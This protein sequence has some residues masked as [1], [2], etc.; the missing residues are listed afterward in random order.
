[1]RKAGFTA[2]TL[3]VAAKQHDDKWFAQGEVMTTEQSTPPGPCMA[4][5]VGALLYDDA[6]AVDA[7]LTA[8]V[9]A[10][11]A[12]GVVVGGLLQRFGERLSNGKQ[13]M[14][15]DDIATGRR[16]RLD[17]P[18]GPGAKACTLDLDALA[19]ASCMLRYTIESAP[20][21][22]V[23]NRFGR[24][25]V[26]GG[27]MRAEIAEA[28]CSGAAVLIAVR[29]SRLDQLRDFLGES[30]A[31]VMPSPQAIADWAERV[32]ASCRKACPARAAEVEGDQ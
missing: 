11:R 23:V 16:I 17:Q 32:T 30:P 28:I 19:Q 15:L 21:L 13:S 2:M 1:M 22:I 27:G 6:V 12:R 4:G 10:I 3:S 20:A 24:A 26:E 25:E 8:A 18:R 5:K 14:W 7:V 9:A 31:P 29:S